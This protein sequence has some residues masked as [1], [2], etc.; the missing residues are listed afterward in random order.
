MK[1]YIVFLFLFPCLISCS[2]RDNSRQDIH[3][4]LERWNKIIYLQPAIILDSLNSVETTELSG[5]N[6]AYWALLHT[7][8]FERTNGIA[9]NDSLISLS[10]SW[11]KKSNDHYN[12]CRSLL[13]KGI[14]RY[15][16][17]RIDS[18]AYY[19]VK[20]AEMLYIDNNMDDKYLSMLICTYLG[21]LELSR[22][23]DSM[24]LRYLDKSLELSTELKSP[25]DIQNARLTL[26]WM[27]LG[28]RKLSKALSNIIIFEDSESISPEMEYE[29]YNALS[30]YYSV[31]NEYN[32]SIE[33]IKKMIELKKRTNL[34]INEPRLY[35]SLALNFKKT[36]K[37]DSALYYS[38]LAV[39]A[40]KSPVSKDDHFYYRYLA[41]IYASLGNNTKAFENYK[42]AYLS[43]MSAYSKI[44]RNRILEIEKKYDLSRKEVEMSELKV[45]STFL[46]NIVISL[47]SFAILVILIFRIR[48][49]NQ[50]IKVANAEE[51]KCSV[52]TELKKAWFLNELLKASAALLPQFVD[53][54][55]REAVRGRKISK[56][57]A[58]NLN[59]SIDNIR[60]LSR[61]RIT[62][63][64]KNDAFRSINT[65]LDYFPDLSDFEKIIL[66]LIDYNYSVLEISE[67]LNSSPSSIR[68]I[69]TKIKEKILATEKLPFDPKI[70]FSIFK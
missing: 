55:N 17:N 6:A 27:Y 47:I 57:I 13:Y 20:E 61:N 28:Q 9:E 46:L 49:K 35:Y 42:M 40:I 26:F 68:S 63:I 8:A 66:I 5:E 52:E 70:T 32:I 2:N 43:Y 24:A 37:L 1:K 64:A 3:Q 60:T 7:I 58:D 54:V 15:R 59:S 4:K 38:Q 29:L 62:A 18:S 45:Q 39:N 36:D 12:L 53:D 10:L 22:S 48:I 56:E 34:K 31:K 44:S 50:K 25:R 23:N 21:R 19:P 11:Y 33:Y 41:D 51:Q 16:K 67:L 69:K 30:A 65:N 14:V